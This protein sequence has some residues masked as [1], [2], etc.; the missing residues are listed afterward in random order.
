M[1]GL[2]DLHA[3]I[4]RFRRRAESRQRKAIYWKGRIKAD[5]AAIENLEG[6]IARREA[7]LADWIKEHGVVFEGENKVRGGTPHQRLRAA[8]LRAW[9][10]YRKSMKLWVRI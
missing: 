10:N 4:D 2:C 6:R 7:E 1:T 9:H 5:L 8:I 3:R